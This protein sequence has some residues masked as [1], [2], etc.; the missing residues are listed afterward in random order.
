MNPNVS[1][2]TLRYTIFFPLFAIARW[3]KRACQYLMGASNHVELAACFGIRDL[4]CKL[5]IYIVRYLR[6][7]VLEELAYMML[8]SVAWSM[9]N[10][11][12]YLLSIF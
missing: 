5:F 2:R 4:H 7:T 8:A 1:I 10:S 6:N 3:I 9:K 12:S 11:R